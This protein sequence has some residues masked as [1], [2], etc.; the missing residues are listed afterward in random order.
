MS[1]LYLLPSISR[2]TRF[3]LVTGVHTCALPISLLHH[4][5]DDHRRHRLVS[6]ASRCRGAARLPDPARDDRAW[7]LA[8]LCDRAQHRLAA[9]ADRIAAQG[10]EGVMGALRGILDRK[11]TRLNSSH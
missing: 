5:S 6:A 8:F 4:P 1:V 7:V 11:S 2:P 9:A 10:G 3:A